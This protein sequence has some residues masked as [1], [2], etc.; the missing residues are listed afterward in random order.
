MGQCLANLCLDWEIKSA[1]RADH[2]EENP[3]RDSE[4][5]P[6]D[7]A[8][9]AALQVVLLEHAISDLNGVIG[10]LQILKA[11]GTFNQL[12]DAKPRKVMERASTAL[13][14]VREDM[15]ALLADVQSIAAQDGRHRESTLEKVD[16]A[17]ELT[18]NTTRSARCLLQRG[19]RHERQKADTESP[20]ADPVEASLQESK[21]NGFTRYILTILEIAISDY[22][23]H[24]ILLSTVRE[25]P[26]WAA[27]NNTRK[28]ATV[29]RRG[30]KVCQGMKAKLTAVYAAVETTASDEEKCDTLDEKIRTTTA[31]V[32]KASKVSEK[33][34]YTWLGES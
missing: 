17:K 7:A 33:L 10:D 5:P 27:T 1:P 4:I 9:Y 32:R 12:K 16:N 24:L 22:L 29:L 20:I 26:F 23:D 8:A 18:W 11:H 3:R 15:P 28:L 34:Y 6:D 19:L 21:C 2:F 14:Q 30:L 31:A 25:D 13:Q